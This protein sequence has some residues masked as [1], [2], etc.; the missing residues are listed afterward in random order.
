MIAKPK[1]VVDMWILVT[2]LVTNLSFST[3]GIYLSLHSFVPLEHFV[4]FP[5]LHFLVSLLSRDGGLRWWRPT[6]RTQFLRFADVPTEVFTCVIS[7]LIN[8]N[9]FPCPILC[10]W[11]NTESMDMFK[12]LDIVDYICYSRYNTILYSMLVLFVVVERKWL[13]QAGLEIINGDLLQ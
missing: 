2:F 6:S 9:I 4:F 1:L 8:R 10:I 11:M 5:R 13:V 12:F 3:S 7:D